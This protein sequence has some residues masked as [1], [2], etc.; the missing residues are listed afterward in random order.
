MNE[1]RIVLTANRKKAV[2]LLI[3]AL[4]FTVGGAFMI[5]DGEP[6]GWAV[7]GFF[8]LC[9]LVAVYMLTPNA[10]RLTID[11][12]GIEMKTLFKPMTLQW[13]DVDEFYVTRIT[14]THSSTKMIGIRYSPAYQKMRAGRQFSAALTGV[15]GALPNHFSM[16]A[17]ELCELLNRY[18]LRWRQPPGRPASF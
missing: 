8:G 2:L 12:D 3:G 16:P 9:A 13:S 14:T 4:A 15:E 10:I 17:E 1:E 7:T 6:W 18:R 11:R 5:R